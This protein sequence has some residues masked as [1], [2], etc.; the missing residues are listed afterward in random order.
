MTKGAK[1]CGFSASAGAL[2]EVDHLRQDLADLAL[3]AKSL[4]LLHNRTNSDLVCT[5]LARKHIINVVL[6]KMR[7]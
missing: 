5:I 1:V 6:A 3:A 4:V 7:S 2:A